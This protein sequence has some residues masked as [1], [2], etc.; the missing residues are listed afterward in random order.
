MM[1]IF[2]FTIMKPPHPPVRL[3]D[4]KC[5]CGF[6]VILAVA[7]LGP[8]FLSGPPAGIAGCLNG[9]EIVVISFKLPAT[10]T[11][12][13]GRGLLFPI[14][15]RVRRGRHFARREF[16]RLARELVVHDRVQFTDLLRY[17]AEQ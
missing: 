17:F 12:A 2:P 14:A 15:V 8:F 16:L 3:R 13:R 9:T 4:E 7:M 11:T 1:M 10:P 5:D 6:A